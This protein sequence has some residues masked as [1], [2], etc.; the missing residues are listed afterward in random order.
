MDFCQKK[1][2]TS[3]SGAPPSILPLSGQPDPCEPKTR[4]RPIEGFYGSLMYDGAAQPPYF[5][6]K[7][8]LLAYKV[9]HGNQLEDSNALQ[10]HDVVLNLPG[11]KDYNP[12]MPWVY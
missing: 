5:T 10:W 7:N 9:T 4:L 11:S 1:T 8:T 12:G 2:H 6:I 3:K